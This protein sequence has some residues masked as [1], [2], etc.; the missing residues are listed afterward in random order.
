M[1]NQQAGKWAVGALLLM[2]L[3][4]CGDHYK[5]GV[6]AYKDKK[7]ELAM[8]ALQPLADEGKAE[9]QLFVGFMYDNGEGVAVDYPQAVAWYGKAAEQGEPTAQYNLAMMYGN[10]LGVKKDGVQ[11]LKWLTLA[12]LGGNA[13]AAAAVSKVSSSLSPE[14][15]KE[16]ESQSRAWLKQRDN[17]L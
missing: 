16:A 11:T 8:Q 5:E 1:W 14:H 4:G 7:F 9:A 13:E 6:Q 15:V 2:G 3:A 10:G 17:K 12:A